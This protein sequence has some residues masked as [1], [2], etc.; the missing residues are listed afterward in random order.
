LLASGTPYDFCSDGNDESVINAIVE[1]TNISAMQKL[2][3]HS[4]IVP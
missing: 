1:Q 2:L 4:D 3:D